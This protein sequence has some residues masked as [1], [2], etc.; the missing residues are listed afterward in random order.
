LRRNITSSEVVK[1]IQTGILS[2]QSDYKRSAED[3]ISNAPEYLCTVRTYNTILRKLKTLDRLSGSSSGFITLEC[4]STDIGKIVKRGPRTRNPLT[5]HSH[6]DIF[7][8][9]AS[10]TPRAV[11]EIKRNVRNM[12]G[13]QKDV[14]RIRH[15]LLWCRPRLVFGVFCT[16][17][18]RDVCRTKTVKETTDLVWGEIERVEALITDSAAGLSCSPHYIEPKVLNVEDDDGKSHT[19]LWC[20]LCFTLRRPRISRR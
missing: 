17:V 19:R 3:W 4:L 8:W 14:E 13:I 18:Y 16:I 1:A 6:A 7:L 15:F 5:E 9:A 11:I 10:G 20:P 12:Q 2:A